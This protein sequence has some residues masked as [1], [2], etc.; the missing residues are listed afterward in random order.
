MNNLNQLKKSFD[1]KLFGVAGGIAEYLNADAMY[2]RLAFVL[3]ALIF[4]PVILLYLVLAL[5]MPEPALEEEI[6]IDV[7]DAI[8]MS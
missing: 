4:E 1:K 2:V 5:I 6:E 8:K 7:E 3:L